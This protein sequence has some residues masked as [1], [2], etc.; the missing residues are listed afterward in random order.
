MRLEAS[1]PRSGV[2]FA[3][4]VGIGAAAE[5]ASF[6]T[7]LSAGDGAGT[8]TGAA[9]PVD[10]PGRGVAFEPLTTGAGRS[11]P[12]TAARAR[13]HARSNPIDSPSHAGRASAGGGP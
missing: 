5:F 8:G 13:S 11:W 9:G 6:W 12:R 4:A 7:G 2:E 10:G 1:A 3:G